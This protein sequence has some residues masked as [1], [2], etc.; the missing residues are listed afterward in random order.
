MLLIAAYDPGMGVTPVGQAEGEFG[1][2]MRLIGETI[3]EAR[4]RERQDSVRSGV[5]VCTDFN[6]HHPL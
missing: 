1:H 3:E 6:R 5:L 4:A 2:K